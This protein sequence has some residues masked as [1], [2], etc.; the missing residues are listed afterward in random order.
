M[1]SRQ[2][3]AVALKCLAIYLLFNA[4]LAYPAWIYAVRK[5][6][7]AGIFPLATPVLTTLIV[8]FCSAVTVGFALLAWSMANRLTSLVAEAPVDNIHLNVTPRHLEEILFRVLGVYFAV[9]YVKPFVGELIRRQKLAG[10]GYDTGEIQWNLFASL[11]VLVFGLF[12]TFKP[13]ALIDRLDRMTNTKKTQAPT[14]ESR[15]T[16]DPASSTDSEEL[17]L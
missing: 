12:L 7:D 5:G 14:N 3:T 8:I 13:G 9:T 6:A 11:G 1:T 10:G 17:H 2:I 15:T 16:C 4:L